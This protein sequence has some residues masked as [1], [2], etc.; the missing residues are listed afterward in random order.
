[1]SLVSLNPTTGRLLARYREHSGPEVE[2][3]LARAIAA[4]HPWRETPPAERAQ[5]LRAVGRGLLLRRDAL[6]ALATAEMGKPITQARAEI[7]KCARACDYFAEHGPTLL[8]DEHPPGTPAD[9]RVVHEPIGVV[10]GIMPWNF[11]YWQIV[12]GAIPALVGGNAVLLKPAPNVTG[13][14]LALEE[15]F[16]QAGVSTGVF[17][18][19]LTGIGRIPALIADA[20]VHAVTFT[21]S[22]GAGREVAALAGAA[23]K[24]GVYELG[25]S[26]A[27]LVLDD[28]DLSAA[29][30]TCV[31]ARLINSGQSCASAKRFIVA[32]SVRRKFEQLVTARIA[33]RRVGDPADPATAVG[34]LARADLRENLQR[35][36]SASWRRG[37]RLLLGGDPLPGPGF[38]YAPTVL[39]DVRP[40][41]PAADEELF[42]PAAAILIARDEA[43]AVRLANATPYGLG[44]AIFTRDP[45]RAQALVPQLEAGFV[46]I[47]TFVRSHP[48]LPFGGIKGSGL[49]RELGAHGVRAFLNLKTVVG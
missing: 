39:T 26:D 47:N 41:M 23:M 25:G 5:I 15:V 22:T 16:T 27:Y 17:Q 49:G 14:A 21:G 4:R 43:D 34:P 2:R 46:A 6:A 32:R 11:P 13:C 36:I 12:R 28:A 33:A 8:A 35:Q 10:L 48:G 45:A 24:P 20:R 42:G 19:L 44:A 1:M 37:A 40:G 29:A 30:E 9:S 7:E 31:A 18:L 38:F 3:R